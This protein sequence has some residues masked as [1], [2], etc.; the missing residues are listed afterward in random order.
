MRRIKELDGLRAIAILGVLAS[1]FVH[2]DTY[3]G[4]FLR[5]G[6]T[7]VDLFFAISGF[8]I[9]GILIDLRGR[10]ASFRTF[11]WRRI[12]RIFPPYYI[13]L[14][15]TLV[16]AV[17]H[18]EPINHRA[19]LRNVLFLSSAKPALVKATVV[20]MFT[21]SP[22]IAPATPV[23]TIP[24]QPSLPSFQESF[25]VYWSLSVEELFYLIWAPILLKGSR[26]L[27]ILCLTAPLLL[28]PLLRGLA[29]TSP[30]IEESLGFVFR[31]DSLAAGGCVALIFYGLKSGRFAPK[32]VDRALVTTLVLSFL[33]L[34]VL[35]Q[36]CGALYGD[37]HTTW[38]F[39]VLGLSVL[40]A[41]CASIVAACVRWSG[42]LGLGSAL[43]T[44]R[45]VTYLGK[46]S[47]T[48]YLLHVPVYILIGLMSIRFLGRS[49]VTGGRALS[50]LC[51]LLA[52]AGVIAVAG[53]SW[54]YI[55]SPILR[56]KDALFP[57]RTRT[58]DVPVEREVD[59]A[60]PICA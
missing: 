53:L 36:R 47:Y 31:F 39:S 23:P 15:L 32:V 8:L 54:K 60:D 42:K 27:I 50:L 6:W 17:L 41:T 35:A 19:V 5:L 24:S 58:A 59:P 13:A 44:S 48:V 45:P 57:L 10:E 37:V 9:T 52:T 38:L 14:T 56:L 1:H 2:E 55:E 20:R 7:G 22:V 30:H 4:H 33:G 11:Y 51:S 18:A 49:P 40:A 34:V 29:H 28:C 46:V 26:R 21:G 3:F 12:L 25:G 16:L 43:L